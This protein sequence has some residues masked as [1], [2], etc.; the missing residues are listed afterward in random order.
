MIDMELGEYLVFEK[1]LN[2]KNALV[3]SLIASFKLTSNL[4]LFSG[5]GIE[6][7]REHNLEI[8][9]LGGEYAFRFKKGW[10]LAPGFFYDIKE[11]YD[12]FSLS[13]A[14]GKEF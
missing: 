14:V 7:E 13:V 4:N 5:G 9:R 2:R 6:L 1:D 12:S 8:I 11:G 3:I 10:L